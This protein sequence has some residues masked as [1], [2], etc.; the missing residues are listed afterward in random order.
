GP[1]RRGAAGADAPGRAGRAGPPLIQVGLALER[2]VVDRH[3][4]DLAGRRDWPAPAEPLVEAGPPERVDPPDRPAGPLEPAQQ[5]D[6]DGKQPGQQRRRAQQ[7]ADP[8]AHHRFTRT[9]AQPSPPASGSRWP[10]RLLAHAGAAAP[11]PRVTS[12]I[13]PAAMR[14]RSTG[15]ATP[16][17]A[18]AT[19]W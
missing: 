18:A 15:V 10:T 9:T 13:A 2:V 8:E 4:H 17:C 3:D 1:A 6:D 16:G 11:P 7:A 5:G 19:H 12:A 14:S